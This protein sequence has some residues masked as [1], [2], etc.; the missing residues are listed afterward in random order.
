[1]IDQIGRA[2]R[3]TGALT[4]LPVLADRFEE[5]GVAS[6]Q[7]FRQDLHVAGLVRDAAPER[8]V[9]V[10]S[11]V[12]GFV[13][14]LLVFRSVEV[15]DI[16][17]LSSDVDGLT[18]VQADATTMSGFADASVES[19][20]SLHA[21]EHFGLGRYG[22]LIDID[23]PS[24]VTEAFARILAPDGRLYLSA[25]VGRRRVEFNAHRVFDPMDLPRMLSGLDL[26]RFDGMGDDGVFLTDAD[27]ANLRDEGYGLGIYTF[28]KPASPDPE[29]T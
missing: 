29:P 11:R 10:G 17:P 13:A 27:P 5:A 24:K 1:M 19:L 16:R 18:F 7:Y 2:A 4:Y 9:D 23:A 25:P 20:S 12:D 28:A 22:D 6:D 8:H 21:I 26:V 15:V 3:L 14:H